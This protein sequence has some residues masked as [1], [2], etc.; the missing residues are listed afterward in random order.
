MNKK[1]RSLVPK[2]L[3]CMLYVNGYIRNRY[4]DFIGRVE[5]NFP[6][7]YPLKLSMFYK[8]NHNNPIIQDYFN[9]ILEFLNSPISFLVKTKPVE[10]Y[11]SWRQLYI[12]WIL[13]LNSYEVNYG[14]M[15]QFS[16]KCICWWMPTQ[17]PR[18]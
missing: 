6:W 3:P 16:K 10:L 2:V 12:Y 7:S 14:I 15:K 9:W 8:I 13:W 4:L 11:N 17:K 5:P 1:C 18:R